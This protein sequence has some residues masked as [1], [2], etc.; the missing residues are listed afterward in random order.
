MLVNNHEYTNE[1]TMFPH[2]LRED[3]PDQHGEDRHSGPRH[4][5][6]GDDPRQGGGAWTVRARRVRN[7]R[8]TLTTPFVVDGPRPART[9]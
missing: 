2:G 5:G 8:I 4:V 6:R 1:N 3:Q 9:C 7:R